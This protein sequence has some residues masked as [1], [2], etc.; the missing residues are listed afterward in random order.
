MAG[1][2][3]LFLRNAGRR[4][5]RVCRV[6]S[7][8]GCCWARRCA[9]S[10]GIVDPIFG[11]IVLFVGLSLLYTYIGG[12][13][14]VIWTDAVQFGLFLAGGFFALGLHPDADRRRCGRGAWRQAGAAGKLALVEHVVHV[15]GAV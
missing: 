11:A 3:F 1:G 2:F 12:V 5:A 13:K 10:A 6:H 14:A 9:V 8:S 15:L 7:R 4:R